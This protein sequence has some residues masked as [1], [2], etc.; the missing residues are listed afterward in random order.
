MYA[1]VYVLTQHRLCIRPCRRALFI[2]RCQPAHVYVSTRL[3]LTCMLMHPCARRPAST[4]ES[5]QMYPYKI[6]TDLGRRP[7]LHACICVSAYV[8]A[9]VHLLTQHRLCIR[10]CKRAFFM[11][12]L[13]TSVCIHFAR[14]QTYP[15]KL[16]LIHI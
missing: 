11:Q 9:E 13:C 4:W 8:Y 6:V 15:Y 3:L 7:E 12:S 5:L 2:H 1:Y 14:L 10:P 16:S